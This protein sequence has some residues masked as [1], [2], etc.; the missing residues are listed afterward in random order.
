MNIQV[1]SLI[2]N[3]VSSNFLVEFGE[4]INTGTD[5]FKAA[6]IDSFGYIQLITFLQSEFHITFSD[7]ELLTDILVSVDKIVSCVESKIRYSNL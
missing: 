6:V 1:A 4:E 7:E 5:L 3:F 2:K